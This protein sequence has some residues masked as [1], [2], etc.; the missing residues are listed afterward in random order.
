MPKAFA[1]AV[2]RSASTGS[3]TAMISDPPA[4]CDDRTSR[5]CLTASSLTGL[6]RDHPHP[7]ALDAERRIAGRA[8]VLRKRPFQ[9][10]LEQLRTSDTAIAGPAALKRRAERTSRDS[11]AS[12]VFLNLTTGGFSISVSAVAF[13]PRRPRRRYRAESRGSRAATLAGRDAS[14]CSGRVGVE[15]DP[16]LRGR[17]DHAV[18]HDLDA[19][20]T[21]SRSTLRATLAITLS[22]FSGSTLEGQGDLDRLGDAESRAEPTDASAALLAPARVRCRSRPRHPARRPSSSSGRRRRRAS[23]GCAATAG[24]LLL[25]PRACLL[26]QTTLRRR[27]RRSRC[28]VEPAPDSARASQ[29]PQPASAP[30]TRMVAKATTRQRRRRGR[31]W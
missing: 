18:A 17:D 27:P 10:G 29:A 25:E 21:G 30:T 9:R 19:A 5:S 22:S 31:T 11:S 6:R 23:I 7:L 24:D 15:L 28:S 2:V 12:L 16:D 4:A 26:E 3:K 14:I 13:A 8:L 1:S 20:D